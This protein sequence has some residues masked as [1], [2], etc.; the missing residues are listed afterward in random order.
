MTP[1][2]LKE[3]AE[4]SAE[5]LGLTRQHI[6]ESWHAPYIGWLGYTV[7]AFFENPRTAPILMHLGKRELERIEEDGVK[8]WEW[9][10]Q[11]ISW[12]HGYD[13]PCYK[14]TIAEEMGVDKQFES[15]DK[16]EYIAFWSAV[17]Q[18]IKEGRE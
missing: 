15:I 2:E 16:N 4:W 1:T 5:F 9:E 14:V 3:L 12:S 18:A 13:A 11:Y 7:G 10:V 8:K 6:N 17:M